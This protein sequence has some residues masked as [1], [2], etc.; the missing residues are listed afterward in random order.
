MEPLLRVRYMPFSLDELRRLDFIQG[1]KPNFDRDGKVVK[2]FGY[3]TGLILRL[4]G[5]GAKGVLARWALVVATL[6][7]S[8][9][10]LTIKR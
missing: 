6:Y 4:G 8:V 1:K 2:G 7:V 10:G 5:G 9:F 3:W